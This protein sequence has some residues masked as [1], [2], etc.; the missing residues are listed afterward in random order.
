MAS[1]S[2]LAIDGVRALTI[3]SLKIACSTSV[4][5]RP[6][7]SF[8]HDTPAHP[9]S[10]SLRCQARRNSNAASSPCGSRP[11]WFPASQDR[12]SSRNASSAGDRVR[13]T[14]AD[15]IRGRRPI[16]STSAKPEPQPDRAA[17]DPDSGQRPPGSLPGRLLRRPAQAPAARVRPRAAGRR[18]LGLPDQ[19]RP[20]VLRAARRTGARALLDVAVG[21]RGRLAGALVD[22][23][24][25]VIGRRLR[26][27]PGQ[28]HLLARVLLRGHRAAH[29]RRGRP[30]ARSSSGCAG[31]WT[32]RACSSRRRR[33]P[34]A[35][36]RARSA[37]SRASAARRATTSLAGLAAPRLGRAGWSGPSPRCR[38][39]TPR[40]AIAARCPTWPRWPRST[41]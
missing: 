39:A 12:S 19:S 22:G 41:S 7:Y 2:T 6:P 13:S 18:G 1:A 24:Q 30:A 36:S 37:S 5:P 25:V 10:C 21:L 32:P 23:A 14:A 16:G 26:L 34:A 38:I 8:G 40:R 17:H 3:S 31:A 33:C 20:C 29:R 9:A 11:G 28:P 4:A 15:P 27:L 35:A